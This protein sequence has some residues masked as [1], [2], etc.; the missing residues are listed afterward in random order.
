MLP[1]QVEKALA[2]A[3]AAEM[4]SYRKLPGMLRTTAY[5]PI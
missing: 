1:A 4:V 5:R 3:F 2:E